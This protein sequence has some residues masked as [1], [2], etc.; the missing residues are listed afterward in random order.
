MSNEEGIIGNHGKL[1]LLL[2]KSTVEIANIPI[3]KLSGEEAD[4]WVKRLT[5]HVDSCGCEVGS[6]FL[7]I[8][9]VCVLLYGCYHFFY[10]KLKFQ[11][12]EIIVV[13]LF[14]LVMALAGKFVGK[15]IAKVKLK[16]EIDQ[17]ILLL[18]A[19]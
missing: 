19:R 9:A 12:Q 13:M 11:F 16:K 2:E 15:R 1:T 6:V 7:S 10:L 8:S 18:K 17:L 3:E 5:K 4:S 14:C